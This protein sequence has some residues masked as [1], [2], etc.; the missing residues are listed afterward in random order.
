MVEPDI[1]LC[2]AG[3]GASR[4]GLTCRLQFEPGPILLLGHNI[5]RVRDI[6]YV[7]TTNLINQFNH[8]R[9]SHYSNT[10]NAHYCL[11]CKQKKKKPFLATKNESN[12]FAGLE[13][14][15]SL[16]G[17]IGSSFPSIGFRMRRSQWPIICP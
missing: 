5:W 3:E 1:C 2:Y 16:G 14:K 8:H 17:C 12:F 15:F 13:W 6:V 11:S 10:L 9:R 7:Y 4:G